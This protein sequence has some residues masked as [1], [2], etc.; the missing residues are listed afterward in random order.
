MR[1]KRSEVSARR[2]SCR[3]VFAAVAQFC[4]VTPLIAPAL[5]LTVLEEEEEAGSDGDCSADDDTTVTDDQC[6]CSVDEPCSC[7]AGRAE[8]I[9]VDCSADDDTTTPTQFDLSGNDI[10]SRTTVPAATEQEGQS[11]RVRI[12]KM[13]WFPKDT[14][15]D[16]D[17]AGGSS[18]LREKLRVEAEIAY[19][20]LVC[21]GGAPPANA[22]EDPLVCKVCMKARGI[23]K[24]VMA[25]HTPDKVLN[26]RTELGLAEKK[27][28]DARTLYVLVDGVTPEI[29]DKLWLRME[30]VLEGTEDVPPIEPAVPATTLAA[31]FAEET[32]VDGEE[33]RRDAFSMEVPVAAEGVRHSAV[34]A[35]TEPAIP[36]QSRAEIEA[37]DAEEEE[38]ASSSEEAAAPGTTE[39]LDSPLNREVTAAIAKKKAHKDEEKRGKCSTVF[40]S[41]RVCSCC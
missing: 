38:D 14:H 31:S 5:A 37:T 20:L 28:K 11:K 15:L 30:R 25:S 40:V 32:P 23:L 26:K 6:K 39:T 19:D 24:S 35:I 8:A 21:Y 4:H 16:E 17:H 3:H 9:L 18:R 10:G 33:K 29:R 12:S 34:P 36:S 7:I 27:L 22:G 1:K 13:D 2:C 41:P